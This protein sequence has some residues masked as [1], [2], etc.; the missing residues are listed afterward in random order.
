MIHDLRRCE[1]L[2]RGALA[3]RLAVVVEAAAAKAAGEAAAGALGAAPTAVEDRQRPG[4]TSPRVGTVANP[5]GAGA[6]AGTGSDQ[7]RA[8]QAAGLSS[9][10]REAFRARLAGEGGE[11][12]EQ[13]MV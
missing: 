5:A 10:R 2:A 8:L 3:A 13:P 11:A 6:V 1:E 4:S 7:R 9:A 12:H